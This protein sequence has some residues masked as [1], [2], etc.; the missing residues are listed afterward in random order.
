[1]AKDGSVYHDGVLMVD[2]VHQYING[3]NNPEMRSLY[4]D[5]HGV[6]RAYAWTMGH[7][8][9]EGELREI[10]VTPDMFEADWD[11]GY[12]GVKD[13][14]GHCA[15]AWCDKANIHLILDSWRSNRA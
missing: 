6:F 8:R 4:R 11:Y 13:D 15:Y 10:P 5:E 1:M 9:R 12:Y 14:E 7:G 3:V 2:F